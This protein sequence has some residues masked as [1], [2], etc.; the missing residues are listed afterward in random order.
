MHEAGVGGVGEHVRLELKRRRGDLDRIKDNEGLSPA[1][2]GLHGDDLHYRA[3][4]SKQRLQ[5]LLQLGLLDLLRDV[6]LVSSR[7]RARVK[8]VDRLSKVGEWEVRVCV[9]VC[10]RS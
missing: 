4:R 3:V 2:I 8:R 10:V 1:A 5:F 7:S 6:L 9:R